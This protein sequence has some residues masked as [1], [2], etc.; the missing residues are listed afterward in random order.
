MAF[1]AS[2]ISRSLDRTISKFAAVAVLGVVAGHEI[3]Q[4]GSLE[5]VRLQCE[6]HVRPQV[7]H[8]QL[9]GPGFFLGGFGIEKQHVGFDALG[10]ENA[11]GQ[12]QQGVD[13][14]LLEQIAAGTGTSSDLPAMTQRSQIAG[15]IRF[16]GAKSP[17]CSSSGISSWSRGTTGSHCRSPSGHRIQA[18]ATCTSG[19]WTAASRRALTKHSTTLMD[20][21][22]LPRLPGLRPNHRTAGTARGSWRGRSRSLPGRR[23]VVCR[24]RERATGYVCWEPFAGCR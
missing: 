14:A 8:P 20:A 2:S 16:S 18:G 6:V 12:A 22:P 17:N 24:S 21:P 1:N 10:V 5:W 9:L 7:I 3:V 15:P 11:G 13:V 23:T 4:V 19:L